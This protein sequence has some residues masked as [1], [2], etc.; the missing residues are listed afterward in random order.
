MLSVKSNWTVT[1]S[2]IPNCPDS[3]T[4]YCAV[5]PSSVDVGPVIDQSAGPSGAPSGPWVSSIIVVT[6]SAVVSIA[7]AAPVGMVALV[8]AR[9][10]SSGPSINTSSVIPRLMTRSAIDAPSDGAV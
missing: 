4:V 6:S 2:P 8:K 1:T 5:D 3:E 10:K 7:T 9:V